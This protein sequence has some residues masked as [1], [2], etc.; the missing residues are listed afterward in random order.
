MTST[1]ITTHQKTRN[2]LTRKYWHW[3]TIHIK[4]SCTYEQQLDITNNKVCVMDDVDNDTLYDTIRKKK[5]H[6]A[7]N[8]IFVY[9]SLS[10]V[11]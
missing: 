7:G 4:I 9:G 8:A 11:N 2:I 10:V 1:K 5:M 3:R 6:K